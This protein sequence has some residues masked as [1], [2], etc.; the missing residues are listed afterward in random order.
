MDPDPTIYSTTEIIGSRPS[1]S[2]S[3]LE[4]T[5]SNIAAAAIWGGALSCLLARFCEIIP[6]I[7]PRP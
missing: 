4:D 6:R 5:L 7:L 2:L 1:I 3:A